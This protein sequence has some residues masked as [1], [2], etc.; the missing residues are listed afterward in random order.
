MRTTLNIDDDVLEAV[1]SQARIDGRS[2]GKVLSDLVRD[3]LRYPPAPEPGDYV[4]HRGF[5][6]L[7]SRGGLVTDEMVGKIREMEGI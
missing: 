1:K 5:V 6:S 7:P 2:V 4:V 3:S